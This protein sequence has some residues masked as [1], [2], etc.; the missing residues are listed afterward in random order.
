MGTYILNFEHIYTLFY[1]ETMQI[2]SLYVYHKVHAKYYKI[3]KYV[4]YV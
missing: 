2:D 1:T 3:S 4:A